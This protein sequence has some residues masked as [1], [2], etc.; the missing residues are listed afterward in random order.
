MGKST[1]NEYHPDTVSAPGETLEEVL[2]D[3][4][5]NQV[6]LATRT[7]RPVKTINEIIKGKVAITPETA[8]QFERALGVPA[9]FWNNL[10]KNYREHLARR[11]E[12]TK[13]AGYGSWLKEIP[14]AAMARL[15]WIEKRS[16]R[17]EQVRECLNF[18]G[19]ASPDQWR[20]VHAG[21]QAAF[22]RSTSFESR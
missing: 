19:V 16:D 1:R 20:E 10:E 21:L 11:E 18:Y 13:L 6:E 3:R 8:L 5:M 9:S 4:E 12:S 17:I 7:G 14:V 2:A 22:R 15:G